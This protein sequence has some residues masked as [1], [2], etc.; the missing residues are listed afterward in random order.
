M[1]HIEASS[2]GASL[3]DSFEGA[4]AALHPIVDK[5]LPYHQCQLFHDQLVEITLL[6][7]LRIIPREPPSY[8]KALPPFCSDKASKL[9]CA[10]AGEHVDVYQG[11][12]RAIDSEARVS[13]LNAIELLK[14]HAPSLLS[15]SEAASLSKRVHQLGF[16][17][18]D[19][20]I[21]MS[22]RR[23]EG[24]EPKLIGQHNDFVSELFSIAKSVD[25]KLAQAIE[26]EKRRV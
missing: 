12:Q 15:E 3:I 17:I 20:D 9:G 21:Q 23:G 2:E 4:Y 25:E 14:T 10:H 13:V 11:Q 24:L 8:G 26:L 5:G 19:L 18:A 6:D 22:T 16:W 7:S 1:R